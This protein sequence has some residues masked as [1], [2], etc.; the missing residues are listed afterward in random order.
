MLGAARPCLGSVIRLAIVGGACPLGQAQGGTTS[1]SYSM[2][3]REC[4]TGAPRRQGLTCAPESLARK[5][6]ARKSYPIKAIRHQWR[7]TAAP[8]RASAARR[9]SSAISGRLAASRA[10]A[11][12]SGFRSGRARGPPQR[13]LPQRDALDGAPAEEAIDALADHPGEML[14]LD[15]GRSFDPQNQRARRPH[16]GVVRARPLN[17]DRLADGCDLGAG[18]FRPARDQFGRRKSLPRKGVAHDLAEE[19]AQRPGD[20]AGGLVH[21]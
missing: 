1:A 20:G 10:A 21:A 9:S 16:P 8:S 12:A 4:G 7:L 3:Q 18:N 6:F 13:R 11:A 14:N 19:V 15:R 2:L 17:F 5:R